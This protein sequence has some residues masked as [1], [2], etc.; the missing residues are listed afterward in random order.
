MNIRRVTLIFNRELRDQLRDR[1]TLFSIMIM[2]LLL[3]PLMGGLSLQLTH[4][5]RDQR[6][7]IRVL[8]VADFDR[9]PALFANR[10]QFAGEWCPSSEAKLLELRADLVPESG[11]NL[12]QLTQDA[13]RDI[14]NGLYDMVIYFPPDFGQSL[15]EFRERV[16]GEREAADP[17]TGIETSQVPAPV[18]LAD[19]VSEKSKLALRRVEL[20][21][22]RW[23]TAVVGET[24]K[25]NHVSIAATQP[26]HVRK[27]DLAEDRTRRAVIWSRLMPF[28]ILIWSI[29]GA[30]YPAVDLCAGEKE[31]GTMETLLSSPASRTEVVLG[32]L[33]TIF[34][35]SILTALLNMVSLA[36]TA[37][38]FLQSMAS[39]PNLQGV[40]A[41]PPLL[42]YVW[43]FV[44]MLPVSLLF[45]ALSLAVASF[46]RSSKEGQYYLLP[47]LFSGLPLMLAALI[48]SMELNFGTSVI[49]VTGSMLLMRALIDERYL[50]ALQYAPFVTAVTVLS[51]YLACRWAVEQFNNEDVLFRE[52]E[53]FQ[54]GPW[55]KRAWRDRRATPA[56]SAA[57]FG[58]LVILVARLGHSFTSSKLPTNW[59]EFWQATVVSLGAF[60]GVGAILLALLFARDLRRT[61]SLTN[62]TWHH[63]A[64]GPGLALLLHPLGIAIATLVQQVYQMNDQLGEQLQKLEHIF[65]SAPNL[66]AL[67]LVM[68]VTP[69]ICEELLFRGFALSGLRSKGHPWLAIGISS[70]LFGVAHQVLQQSIT[71][72]LLGVVLGYLV[73]SLGSIWP[74]ILFHATYNSLSLLL[75]YRA[76]TWSERFPPL[77]WLVKSS[78]EAGQAM[79]VSYRWPVIALSLVLTL[80]IG[81][82][83][84]WLHRRQHLGKVTEPKRPSDS[85][86]HLD[87]S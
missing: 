7:K 20:V 73:V 30:F 29:T 26:F 40:F 61:L 32:K 55:L 49:P 80:A 50:Q 86:S 5:L 84:I 47:L 52:S 65:T 2:P 53:R 72:C 21:L 79:T 67:L 24:L 77:G 60:F 82:R 85:Q 23:R 64:Y 69:A 56:F 75:V 12:E 27:V 70:L 25:Q 57:L 58:T 76:A 22:G 15:D 35:I 33:L 16:K 4:F 66:G 41:P 1:R 39:G 9:P 34:S 3:Y 6:S 28:M 74:A 11:L 83:Q 14:R 46:A 8:T 59:S 18:M 37:V 10:Q 45:S 43:V 13:R 44:G 17:G 68:A 78:S 81:G 71:A 48:P 42:A 63:L 19:E 87:V 54:L 31:R 38:I 62:I 51:C 36:I